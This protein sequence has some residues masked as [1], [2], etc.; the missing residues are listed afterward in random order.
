MQSLFSNMRL[1]VR[2]TSDCVSML[3]QCLPAL[4]LA[5]HQQNSSKF[6]YNT[7]R[8]CCFQKS[9]ILNYLK[10]RKFLFWLLHNSSIYLLLR[11]RSLLRKLIAKKP[12]NLHC[13]TDQWFTFE[14]MHATLIYKHSVVICLMRFITSDFGL[15]LPA[16]VQTKNLLC[17][18]FFRPPGAL[19]YHLVTCNSWKNMNVVCKTISKA[20]CFSH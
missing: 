1:L 20:N 7:W 19:V 13:W 16:E 17:L 3:G 6:P 15:I 9:I 14:L 5:F 18:L 10:N 12:C 4:L 2:S 8:F 11:K